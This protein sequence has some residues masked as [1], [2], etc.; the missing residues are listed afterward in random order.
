MRQAARAQA[1]SDD[2]LVTAYAHEGANEVPASHHPQLHPTM[3]ARIWQ[4]GQSGN[5]GGRPKSWKTFAIRMMPPE[6]LASRLMDDC[7]L[8]G[9]LGADARR[10]YAEQLEG[11]A[12]QSVDVT[13][14]DSPQVQLYRQM[15]QALLGGVPLN[16][17]DL[18]QLPASEAE[19]GQTFHESQLDSP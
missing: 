15:M 13:A 16:G 8:P 7:R 3:A 18:P 1:D 19:P 9:T 2:A 11:K 5:P 17:T 12:R 4:P 10:W 6:E 14:D